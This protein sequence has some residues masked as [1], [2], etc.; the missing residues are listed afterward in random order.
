MT[1]SQ[2]LAEIRHVWTPRV[3]EAADRLERRIGELEKM[4]QTMESDIKQ[5]V[6]EVSLVPIIQYAHPSLQRLEALDHAP[7]NGEGGI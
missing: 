1:P 6:R 4:V 7:S 5:A 3:Q 2:A